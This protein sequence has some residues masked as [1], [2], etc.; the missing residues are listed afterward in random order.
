MSIH[1]TRWARNWSNFE[2]GDRMIDDFKVGLEVGVCDLLKEDT[3]FVFD[4]LS[5]MEEVE[6][7]LILFG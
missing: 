7:I 5:F 3:E 6:L 4:F 2:V 1:A